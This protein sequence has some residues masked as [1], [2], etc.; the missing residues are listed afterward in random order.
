MPY[1]GPPSFNDLIYHLPAGFI[2]LVDIQVK[3]IIDDI[4]CRS[5]QHRSDDEV[6]E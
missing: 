4:S 2:H 5:D 3:I 1:H 6:D